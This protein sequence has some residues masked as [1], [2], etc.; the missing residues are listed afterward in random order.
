MSITGTLLHV[1]SVLFLVWKHT[2]IVNGQLIVN[3]LKHNQAFNQELVPFVNT[4]NIAK[5]KNKAMRILTR[6]HGH[7]IA[8]ITG[9]PPHVNIPIL[10][11]VSV[12]TFSV[13]GGPLVIQ[14]NLNTEL[15]KEFVQPVVM[16]MKKNSH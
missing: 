2:I 1:T 6:R 9:T 12:V 16:L 7:K 5:S 11:V 8:I 10:K 13:N 3:Q 15:N 14:Q 4:F